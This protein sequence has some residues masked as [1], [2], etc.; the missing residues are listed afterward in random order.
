MFSINSSWQGDF[1]EQSSATT[2]Q[3]TFRRPW[4]NGLTKTKSSSSSSSQASPRKMRS[5]RASTEGYA[6]NASTSTGS[7]DLNRPRK[8]SRVGG[9]STTPIGR[10]KLW[11]EKPQMSLQKNR[12]CCY[13]QHQEV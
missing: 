4:T 3:N 11:E 12:G 9:S 8:L 6:T 13:K 2:G 5:S 10:I 7:K 1:R